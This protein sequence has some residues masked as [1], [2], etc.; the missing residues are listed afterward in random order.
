MPV[1]ANRANNPSRQS[2]T[3]LVPTYQIDWIWHT[4]VL[5]GFR[6]YDKD[7]KKLTQGW[8]LDHDDSLNDRT[9]GGVLDTS[10]RSTCT[11]W[12]ENYGVD[13]PVRG[14][15]YKGEPPPTYYRTDFFTSGLATREHQPLPAWSSADKDAARVDDRLWMP[16]DDPDAFCAYRDTGATVQ[17][18]KVLRER[19]PAKANHVFGMGG[20]YGGA[21]FGRRMVR[22]E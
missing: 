22:W 16:D 2:T 12:K 15:M 10:F 14:G 8:F 7:V 5:C 1:V 18:G 13:Y 20:T 21:P 4:H 11:V 6:A 17:K 9:T 19:N 3:W